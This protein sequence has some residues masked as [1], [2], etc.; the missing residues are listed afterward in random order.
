MSENDQPKRQRDN[1]SQND[2]SSPANKKSDNAE[3]DTMTYDQLLQDNLKLHRIA[4]NREQ[5]NLKLHR[6][7]KNLHRIAKNRSLESL[8][9]VAKGSFNLIR[10]G[11]PFSHVDGDHQAAESE[12]VDFKLH[13]PKEGHLKASP[14][15]S[16]LLLQFVDQFHVHTPD[17]KYKSYSYGSEADICSLVKFA[18]MD[19]ISILE[20][21]GDLF[22]EGELKTKLERSL[23]GCRPDIM[24]VRD[25]K[26]VGL[27]AAEV[28]QPIPVA[29]RATTL[30]EKP[31]V[32]GHA[33]DHAMAM[34]AFGQGTAIVIITSFEESYVCSLNKS[35][36]KEEEEENE[37]DITKRGDGDE[38][39]KSTAR[40]VPLTQSPSAFKTPELFQQQAIAAA[41]SHDSL[42]NT[43]FDDGNI[44]DPNNTDPK[45]LFTKGTNERLIYRTKPYESHQLVKL[46]YTALKVAKKEY[47]ESTRT[48]YQLSS[49]Q[50]YVFPKALRVVEDKA[51]YLWGDLR[52]TLGQKIESLAHGSRNRSRQRKTTQKRVDSD[53]DKSYYI[54]GS[55]GHGATSNVFRALNSSG[56]QVALKVYVKN[57][58][59]KSGELM[60][61][62]NFEKEASEATS[63]EVERLRLFYPFL[64]DKV[65]TVKLFGLH[66]VVMPLFEP[67]L[68]DKRQDQLLEIK[69]V[70][71]M[72]ESHKLK[73]KVEDI[74]WR[75]VGNYRDNNEVKHCILYDLSDLE[76]SAGSFLDE[77]FAEFKRRIQEPEIQ[78]L[79]LNVDVSPS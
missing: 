12:E 35:D 59:A 9:M 45:C 44:N 25:K 53:D 19:A 2:E 1:Q 34:D 51:G 56:K 32:L 27:L 46:A 50:A 58:D 18:F 74:R 76:D 11:V 37:S 48:I 16:F 23:F 13:D 79:P 62:E 69:D 77:H 33:F 17:L 67:V 26:G 30:V 63:R 14:A 15:A 49:N 66:C 57:Y 61:K 29:N 7:A 8:V 75:H 68:K 21:E 4:K 31:K 10:T 24:V 5:D 52:V 40:S 65:K 6:I 38:I 36:F 78:R 39:S 28:K 22:E 60:E 73:Y 54:I 70:L 41:V 55:L 3:V 43:S 20:G 64:T 47:E 72:F 71:K 42:D